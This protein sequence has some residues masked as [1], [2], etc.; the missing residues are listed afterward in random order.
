MDEIRYQQMWNPWY[1][2]SCWNK[3]AFSKQA[4]LQTSQDC[5]LEESIRGRRIRNL[6]VSSFVRSPTRTN[7]LCSG[8]DLACLGNQWKSQSPWDWSGGT[9]AQKLQQLHMEGAL[10]TTLNLAL[11]WGEEETENW[12]NLEQLV[13]TQGPSKS[14]RS[15]R[16]L[17]QA[18]HLLFPGRYLSDLWL[19]IFWLLT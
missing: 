12:G 7:S 1:I 10:L 8:T 5:V 15:R 16:H 19:C 13:Q 2:Q 11:A 6:F 14:Y 17:C 3:I 18:Q 4:F 9:W